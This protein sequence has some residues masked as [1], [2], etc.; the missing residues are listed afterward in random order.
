MVPTPSFVAELVVARCSRHHVLVVPNGHVVDE[1][2]SL[3][4]TQFCDTSLLV[5]DDGFAALLSS[6]RNDEER[7][8]DY[9]R[10]S[11]DG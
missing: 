11:T 8:C 1:I 10:A 6:P 9:V 2:L 5:L 7:T 4:A 3:A